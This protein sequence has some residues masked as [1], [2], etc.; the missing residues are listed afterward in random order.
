M[1]TLR[2]FVRIRAC[3]T[4]AHAITSAFAQ[5]APEPEYQPPL[6]RKK[7]RSGVQSACR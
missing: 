1:T 5:G 3:G 2:N 7:E 6:G 4:V